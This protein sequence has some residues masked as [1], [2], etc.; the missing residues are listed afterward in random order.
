MG[1]LR[2]SWGRSPSENL[3]GKK[4][5]EKKIE[6]ETRWVKEEMSKNAYISHREIKRGKVG[7]LGRGNENSQTLDCC[8]RRR[9]NRLTA[10]V[11]ASL[12]KRNRERGLEGY[13]AMKLSSLSILWLGSAV[14]ALNFF[15]SLLLDTLYFLLPHGR[16]RL[17]RSIGFCDCRRK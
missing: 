11:E 9:H 15:S 3:L 14:K 2:I 6:Q 5:L 13:E 10:T 1:S 7:R 8:L 16:V 17:G 12:R 4:L